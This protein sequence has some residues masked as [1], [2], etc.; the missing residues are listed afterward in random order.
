MWIPLSL[1]FV[2]CWTAGPRGMVTGQ[3][4]PK[5]SVSVSPEV[6][7]LGG[8]VTVR[9]STT[10]YPGAK[11]FLQRSDSYVMLTPN[12]TKKYEAEFI[13]SNIQIS[14]AGI[15]YCWYGFQDSSAT[16]YSHASDAVHINVTDPGM[17]EPSIKVNPRGP[18]DVG[19][20][21]TIVCEGQGTGLS[22]FLRKVDTREILQVEARPTAK[23]IF[24]FSLV[25]MKDVGRYICQYHHKSRPFVWSMQSDPMELVLKDNSM[26]TI[27]WASGAAGL[28]LALFLLMLVLLLCKKRKKRSTVN[29]GIQPMNRLLEQNAGT[30]HS[31]REDH[32]GVTYAVLSQHSVKIKKPPS[33][34]TGPES[35]IY[36]SVAK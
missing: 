14:D 5:P 36:A 11:F 28:L 15:Y 27:I 24:R 31:D 8:K 32:D 18:Y 6:V 35:C 34:P 13:I 25:K 23:A 33:Q 10:M 4:Y 26:T 9:C 20:N 21:I 7:T 16:W 12:T 29:E 3:S 19:S 22:F 17:P 1:L 2:G 30:D